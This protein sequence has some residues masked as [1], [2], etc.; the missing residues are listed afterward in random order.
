LGPIPSAP[1]TP[2]KD[3]TLSNSISIAVNWTKTTTDVLPVFGYKL[4]ADSGND[5][6]F[7]LIYDG[8]SLP[9]GVSFVYTN[10]S[11]DTSLT[12][13]FYATGVNFNGEGPASNIAYLKP[14]TQP[15]FMA[16]P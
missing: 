5:D 11:I 12:Y 1:S 9:E 13:R 10:S 3:D 2:F 7:N 4:Y 15:L 16:T 8:S 6:S 14:C